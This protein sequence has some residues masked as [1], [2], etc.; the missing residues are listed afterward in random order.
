MNICKILPIALFV[1]FLIGCSTPDESQSHS[2]ASSIESMPMGQLQRLHVCDDI[3]LASQPDATQLR[4]A[5]DDFGVKTVI[6]LRLPSEGTDLREPE[7]VDELG[8]AYYNLG[9]RAPETLTDD[10]FIE[11]RKILRDPN[12]RPALLHCKSANRAGAVW[13]AYRVLDQGVDPAVALQEAKMAGLRHPGHIARAQS[14]VAS[15]MN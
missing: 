1:S 13:Y 14:Y 12:N 5:R 15:E 9:F 11:T 10:I 6:N 7:I 2:Q 4:L 3:L 8:M